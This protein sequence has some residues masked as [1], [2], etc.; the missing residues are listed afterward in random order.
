VIV[1]T[2]DLAFVGDLVGYAKS[3]QVPVTERSIELTGD[4]HPGACV[5]AHPWKAKD[6]SSRINELETLLGEI[7]RSRRAWNQDTYEERTALWA[8]RLSEAWERAVNLEIVYKVVDRGTSEV[9]P[10]MFR[11]LSAITDDDN[12][13]FQAG[14]GQCSQWAPRHDKD[15]AIN[16]V[17]PEPEDMESE[18]ERFREWFTRIKRYRQQA[19]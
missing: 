3:S 17:A 13:D 9:R 4:R 10:K 16:F 11:L 18:L 7:R 8:G 19:R 12:D 2:H 15:P 6:V 5:D 14:Y 1:F